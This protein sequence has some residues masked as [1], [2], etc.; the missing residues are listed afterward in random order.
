MA[1]WGR[2]YRDRR[3][4]KEYNEELVIRGTFFLDLDFVS[5]WNSELRKMNHGK[6]GSPYLFP[7]SFM[8]FMLIWKQFLDYRAL[9]GMARSLV[10]MR[11]IPDYGDYT[12]IWHRIHDMKPAP[13]ISGLKYADL[14]TDGTGMKT[15]NAGTY[16][17]MKYGDPDAHKRKHLVVIIT[18]DVRTKKIIGIESHVEGSGPSE[19]ETAGKHLRD[20]IMNGI[21]VREFYGD[22]A[23]DT[24]DLFGIMHEI[25]AKPVIKIRKNASTDHYKGNKYRRKEIREYQKKGYR[26][27]AEENHYGMRWPGTEGIFSAV[28]RKF[29]ENCVSRSARGL[30]AEGYQRLWIYDYINNGAKEALR[31][32]NTG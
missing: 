19:P 4:W 10:N 12:T 32:K 26:T 9:E 3:D 28:K 29:G 17:I 14:G 2:L 1:R 24:N 31:I 7:G 20:A 16:R 15:N 11:I 6:R 27:W 13:D 25:N 23:F 8:K 22:G 30:E 18:A 5:Q 21:N